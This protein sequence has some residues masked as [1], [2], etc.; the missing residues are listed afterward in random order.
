MDLRKAERA[1]EKLYARMSPCKL[2][3][4][5]CGVN[6]MEGEAGYC[7]ASKDLRVDSCFAHFGEEAPLSGIRGS[8]TVF[9][10]GCNLKCMF[11][12]NY[13]V[14]H[15]ASGS[16]FTVGELSQRMMGLASEGCHNVNFVTPT[17]YAAQIAEAVLAARR[18]G[19]TGPVI[20][21]TSAYEDP[22]TLQLLSGVV[23]IYMPD[24]KLY[25]ADAA[26]RYLN[27]RDYPEVA[28]D[29]IKLMHLQVG[30]LEIKDGLAVKGVLLRHLVM[31]GM[32]ED[33]RAILRFAAL[34]VSPKTYVNI[35][36]QYRPCY[37]ARDDEKIRWFPSLEEISRI[38]ETARDMGLRL[39]S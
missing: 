2:C 19:Y 1:V 23:D 25:S 36:G 9:L 7:G 32:L 37:R 34:E 14:S 38:R 26:E 39:D 13:R 33:S 28:R 10:S 18:N 15:E 27:A 30:D 17:H 8:G 11:C 6:R 16:T 21:N 20:Y 24:F 31:P 5:Q 12:Q 4:R 29:A 3:P 22:E 35:M